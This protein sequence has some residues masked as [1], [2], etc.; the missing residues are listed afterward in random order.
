MTTPPY[1]NVGVSKSTPIMLRPTQRSLLTLASSSKEIP[2]NKEHLEPGALMIG[3]LTSGQGG[4]KPLVISEDV[5]TTTTPQVSTS[6]AMA[7]PEGAMKKRVAEIEG[8]AKSIEC[9]QPPSLYISTTS[10]LEVWTILGHS[11]FT[12]RIVFYKVPQVQ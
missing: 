11:P 5:S 8:V 7:A 1:L 9:M 6:Q 10:E 4:T 2:S 12:P 3:G